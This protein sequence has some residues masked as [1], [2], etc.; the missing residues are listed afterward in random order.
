MIQ[1]GLDEVRQKQADSTMEN[2]FI[3][4]L[5]S[6]LYTN[7][8]VSYLRNDAE[9][10]GIMAK[11]QQNPKLLMN[12][13]SDKRIM[14][15]MELLIG[16]MQRDANST[17]AQPAPSP[18]PKPEPNPEPKPEPKPELSEEEQKVLAMKTEGNE[19]YKKKQFDQA[20]EKYLA[21][22]EI[23][24]NNFQVRNNVS[25]VYVE[26]GKYDE[27]VAYCQK[28]I[29]IER[30]NHASFE[31]VAKTYMRMGNAELKNGNYD[32]ALEYF[33]SSRTETP[34]KGIDD[35]IKQVNKLREEAQRQAYINPE[36]VC[37]GW[38]CDD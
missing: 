34:L 13:M 14:Q 3:A 26:Q 36:E 29:E 27:C 28:T 4:G 1:R 7:P 17:N 33:T 22:L 9:F 5:L 8:S 32:A 25:A 18:E 35:K 30:D 23:Q 37:V 20:L 31:D 21:I 11:I 12:Y 2:Q 10:M 6:V 16:G 24:P 19:L 38:W 15:L